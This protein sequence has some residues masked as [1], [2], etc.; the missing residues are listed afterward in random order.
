VNKFDELIDADV[1]GVER[2]RLRGVHEL[3]VEAGPPPELPTALEN[4]RPPATKVSPMR[5]RSVPRT[6]AL[7]AAALIALGIAFGMGWSTGHDTAADPIAELKL[8]GTDA[9]PH[10]RATIGISSEVSG[11]WPM[12]LSVSGLPKVTAPEYY[13]VWLVRHGKP[14]APCGE[15]V[16]AKS[17]DSLK[18]KLSAPYSLEP[19]DTWIVTRKRYSQ[20][21]T[22]TAV[23]RPRQLLSS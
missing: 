3:L 21:G 1:A 6:I 4:A 2:E 11:N 5:K 8:T 10:A 18:L 19:G 22:G 15:F 16:V 20:P 17:S 12:T 9:A 7:V 14:L 13:Y 23:L